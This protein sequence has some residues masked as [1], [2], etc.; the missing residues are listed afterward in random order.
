MPTWLK[1]VLG[2]LAGALLLCAVGAGAVYFWVDKNKDRLKDV[3]QRAHREA[4]A[5][6]AN[7]DAT[8]CVQETLR[9][10]DERSGIVDE[11]EH[12]IFLRACL[13]KA[14]R[15]A[16]FCEGVPARGEYIATA[17]WAVKKCQALGRA[18]N[19]PCGRLVQAIQEACGDKPT[20]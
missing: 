16:D 1:V 2:L 14:Q 4:E 12:K 9:R 13:D 7:N 3:G 20:R 6:A 17:E 10:L 15:P 19:Q 5:F 18:G 11:A 8:A